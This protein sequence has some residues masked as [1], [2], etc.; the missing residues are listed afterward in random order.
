MKNDFLSLKEFPKAYFI[1]HMASL[2]SPD[3]YQKEPV[4]T[5]EINT[6][7]TEL[8]LEHARKTG[9]GFLFTSTSEVYGDTQI[10]PT[11][12]SYWGN[13]NPNGV[14][15]RRQEASHTLMTR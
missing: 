14:R 10:I 1:F 6:I 11:P 8:L 13:V 7:G 2:A 4:R 12:E 15:S 5:I 3:Y 9:A